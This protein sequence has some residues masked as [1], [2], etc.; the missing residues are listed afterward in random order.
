[1]AERLVSGR[2]SRKWPAYVCRCPAALG[3]V[4]SGALVD[5]RAGKLRGV[6]GDPL[7]GH[8]FDLQWHAQLLL[9][10]MA[11]VLDLAD[12]LDHAS[13]EQGVFVD[14]G[15]AH[16]IVIGLLAAPGHH[17]GVAS[18]LAEQRDAHLDGRALAKTLGGIARHS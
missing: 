4:P 2:W 16:Q 9:A 15:D 6:Q 10:L 11:V 7:A 5:L 18:L 14:E 8:G 1:M 17:P 12:L 3:L 13:T